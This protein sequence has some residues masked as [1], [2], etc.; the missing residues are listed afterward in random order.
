MKQGLPAHLRRARDLLEWI[1]REQPDTRVAWRGQSLGTWDGI[2][3]RW[4]VAGD[5]LRIRFVVADHDL[6]CRLSAMRHT[7]YGVDLMLEV[8]GRRM[9]EP[10]TLIWRKE[11][12]RMPGSEASEGTARLALRWVRRTF[13]GCR[14]IS[15]T[16]R[17]D[18]AHTLSGSFLRIFLR[19]R[20][21]HLLVLVVPAEDPTD[22]THSALTQAL[23][24]ALRTR[25]QPPQIPLIHV[26]VPCGSS[27]V[28]YHRS[29]FLDRSKVSAFIWEYDIDGEG[30]LR[31]RRAQMP[32]PP[33]E[34]R[35]FRWPVLGPFRWSGPFEQVMELAPSY[36]RRYPRFK[37]YDSLR[38]WGLEFARVLGPKRDRLQFGVGSQQIELT[39][40]NFDGLRQLVDEILYFRRPD[41]PDTQHPFYRMQAER[42][43][44]C[45]ILDEIPRLFPE[46]L[47]ESVYPQIPVYLGKEAGRVDIL[48]TD[49]QGRL[50]VMELK[51][52]QD[53][54]LPLQA[55]DYWGRVIRHN[56]NGDFE[57][58]GYFSGISLE[59]R[60]PRIYLVSPVFSFHD[61]TETLLDYVDS[62]VEVWKVA[63]NE[64][65]RSGVK[66]LRRIRLRCDR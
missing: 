48:G 3:P 57:R 25:T 52:T 24:W 37:D 4:K 2:R 31:A 43:L 5:R 12:D 65:W 1:Q 32:A 33:Q 51:I 42:W 16:R 22:T 10:L 54:D 26:L 47:P 66:L 14:L 49:R 44:E 23:L 18:R 34:G 9:S 64:D 45:L 15:M 56:E 41:S 13:P 19:H 30:Q 35:D 50:V 11:A 46:L 20:N 39:E 61:T 40:N 58:R 28:L 55:L 21:R 8:R 7:D 59:R 63:V 27:G 60:A 62:E 38:L 29:R 6:D 17:P 53:P 36:I